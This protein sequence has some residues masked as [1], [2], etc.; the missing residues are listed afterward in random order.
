[1]RWAASFPVAAA[2]LDPGKDRYDDFATIL[3]KQVPEL[4]DNDRW[5]EF[6]KRFPVFTIAE[7]V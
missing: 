4:E 5:T 2:E 7:K 3:F 6:L 1:M